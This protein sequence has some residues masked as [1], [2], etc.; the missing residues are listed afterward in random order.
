VEIVVITGPSRLD[1]DRWKLISKYLWLRTVPD[2]ETETQ[3]L[4]HWVKGHLIHDG[5]FTL[6][7]VRDYSSIFMR[8]FVGIILHEANPRS[9]PRGPDQPHYMADY[10]VGSGPAPLHG[11]IDLLVAVDKFTMWIEA[12]P[13][14]KICSKLM[15]PQIIK[16]IQLRM[17]KILRLFELQSQRRKYLLGLICATMKTRDIVSY[18]QIGSILMKIKEPRDH[19]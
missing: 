4:A 9:C 17:L 8:E 3:C 19:V 13:Q 15:S 5:A 14:A 7:K 12:R 1:M 10:S 2:D 6:K 18:I 16:S 11:L